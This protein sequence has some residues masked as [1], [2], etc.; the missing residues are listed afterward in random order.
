MQPRAVELMQHVAREAISAKAQI[1]GGVFLTGGGAMIRGLPE[2]AEQ[3]FDAPT[4]AGFLEPSYF[5]GLAEEVQGPQWATVCGLALC[6]MRSQMRG[7]KDW[8]ASRRRGRLPSG[9]GIFA[10]NLDKC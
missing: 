4:R 8:A 1:S 2:I 6:S 3:V 7:S 5:G 10:I 9:L